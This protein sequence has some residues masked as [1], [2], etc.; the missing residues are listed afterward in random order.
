MYGV[1]DVSLPKWPT[2]RRKPLSKIKKLKRNVIWNTTGRPLFAG[3]SESDQLVKI[4]SLLGT[5]TVEGYPGLVDL[6]D[7]TVGGSEV[8][9]EYSGQNPKHKIW[10]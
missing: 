10:S 2:V 9:C 5:P 1:S 7:Y 6:P 3:S 4:F 8:D